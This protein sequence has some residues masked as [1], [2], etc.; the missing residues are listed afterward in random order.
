[1]G[2]ANRRIRDVEPETQG[3]AVQDEIG[4]ADGSDRRRGFQTQGAGVDLRVATH[5]AGGS[6]TQ[7]QRAGSDLDQAIGTRKRS[8]GEN[9]ARATNAGAD[10]GAVADGTKADTDGDSA[11]L[12]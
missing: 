8:R 3:A 5:D 7:R 6:S 12:G 11:N 2:A 4:G 10:V 9:V 1:M